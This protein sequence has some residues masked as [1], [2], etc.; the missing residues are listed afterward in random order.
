MTGLY[1]MKFLQLQCFLYF[2]TKSLL[3]NRRR[4]TTQDE[5]LVPQGKCKARHLFKLLS[6]TLVETHVQL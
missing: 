4:Q 6:E 2:H 1:Y 3:D 5:A